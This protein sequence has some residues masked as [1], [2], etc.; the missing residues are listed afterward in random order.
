MSPSSQALWTR[1]RSAHPEAPP[2]PV[3][4]FHFCDNRNDADL[5]ADLV[6]R[7]VK[8]ATATSLAELELAGSPLPQVG[9]LSIVTRWNGEAVAVI[10]T[11]RVEIRR[12]D[13]IDEDF[14]RLEG[15]GDGTLTWWRD[16]HEAYYRR[17]LQGHG[18][19]V[20]GRLEIAC[21]TFERVF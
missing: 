15:E 14:A 20:D 13:D 11:T 10:L 18:I 3:G 2:S 5:C 4:V 7:G 12:F 19:A 6:L 9:D 17:V 21:E 1:Y 16:A 8:R